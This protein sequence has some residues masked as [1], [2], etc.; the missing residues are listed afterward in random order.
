MY[1]IDLTDEHQFE[2]I[3]LTLGTEL[4]RAGH[5]T[6]DEYTSCAVL[7]DY[8]ERVRLQEIA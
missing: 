1:L 2:G 5:S 4:T 7:N 8:A 6:K 3:Q